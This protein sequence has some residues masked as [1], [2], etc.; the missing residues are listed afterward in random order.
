MLRN[1]DVFH[2]KC[3]E[4]LDV[5]IIYEKKSFCFEHQFHSIRI[6]TLELS[7]CY[8][9]KEFRSSY[10]LFLCIIEVTIMFANNEKQ[11]NCMTTTLVSLELRRFMLALFEPLGKLIV[12]YSL[13]KSAI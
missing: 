10:I 3:Q 6:F 2:M 4:R 5:K 12:Q 9:D 7:I 1:M 11:S 13:M 8:L